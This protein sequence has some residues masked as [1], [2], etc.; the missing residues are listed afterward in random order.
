MD[1]L[2]PSGWSG[3]QK[4]QRDGVPLR[5]GGKRRPGHRD[6][7]R[8]HPPAGAAV[9]GV[10]IQR[11]EKPSCHRARGRAGLCRVPPPGGL[12]L[13]CVPEERAGTG[14]G[15]PQSQ[16]AVTHAGRH[17]RG[18]KTIFA[19][20]QFRQGELGRVERLGGICYG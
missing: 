20:N 19:G 18:A 17:A 9:R 11:Q 3:L 8:H 2:Q 15:L 5:S 14:P 7:E 12:P 6:A 10:G 13:L 1:T 16:P 4:R